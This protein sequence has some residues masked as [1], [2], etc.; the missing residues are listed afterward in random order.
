MTKQCGRQTATE[1]GQSDDIPIFND[2]TEHNRNVMGIPDKKADLRSMPKPVR[3]FGYFFY[4]A[5]AVMTILQPDDAS[6]SQAGDSTPQSTLCSIDP[7]KP[8][9]VR[10]VPV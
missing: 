4:F 8:P 2:V 5:F 7:L 9:F 3:W 1:P 10:A 6:R